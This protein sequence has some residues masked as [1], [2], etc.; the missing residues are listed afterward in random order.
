MNKTPSILGGKSLESHWSERSQRKFGICGFLLI[1]Y[2]IR[3]DCM[4]RTLSP[5]LRGLLLAVTVIIVIACYVTVIFFQGITLVNVWALTGICFVPALFSAFLMWR[6]WQSLTNSTNVLIN[7]IAQTVSMIGLLMATFYVIN[8]A[9]SRTNPEQHEHGVA[10]KVYWEQRYRTRRISRRTYTKGEPYKV[11]FIDVELN[12][13]KKKSIELT[14][15]QYKKYHKGDSL[16][17]PI[18]EGA[19][20]PVLDRIHILPAK[21]KSPKIRNFAD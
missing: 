2:L 13:G 9:T 10:Q 15:R 21:K 8:Y 12:S 6:Y 4:A 16:D 17:I 5:I 19:F 18:R 14:Y 20:A 3:I 11:Y 7:G 1:L